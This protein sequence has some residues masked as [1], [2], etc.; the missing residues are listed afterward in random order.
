MIFS[1][2]M[3]GDFF[4]FLPFPAADP[5]SVNAASDSRV[6]TESVTDSVTGFFTIP[7]QQYEDESLLLLLQLTPPERG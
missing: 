1:C 5:D 2:G 7:V 3:S 6:F 4:P